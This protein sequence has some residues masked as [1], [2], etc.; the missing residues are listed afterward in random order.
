MEVFY[1]FLAW[2]KPAT[3]CAVVDAIEARR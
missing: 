2:D 1:I 3:G